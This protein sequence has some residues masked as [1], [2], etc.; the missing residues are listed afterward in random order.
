MT[1][2]MRGNP[3]KNPLNKNIHKD[4]VMRQHPPTSGWQR[5]SIRFQM[6]WKKLAHLIFPK[7]TK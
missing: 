1:S 2:K 5:L 4:I 6:G 3:L 7:G